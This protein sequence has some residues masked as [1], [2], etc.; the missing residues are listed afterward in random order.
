MY[1][2]LRKDEKQ[3]K[4]SSLNKETKQIGNGLNA[5]HITGI[6]ERE[7]HMILLG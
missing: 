3:N 6:G 7:S 1:N 2:C 5:H 4:L